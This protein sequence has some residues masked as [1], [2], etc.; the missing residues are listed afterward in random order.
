MANSFVKRIHYSL[1]RECYRWLNKFNDY[2]V[3][4]LNQK[5]R[6]RYVAEYRGKRLKKVYIDHLG[7][8]WFYTSAITP[9]V[10][11]ELVDRPEEAD[12]VIFL[13]IVRE[14]LNII[15]K[16]VLIVIREPKDYAQ[17]YVN[18]LSKDF[19]KNNRVTVLSHLDSPEYFIHGRQNL[20]FIR[21]FFYPNFH[22]WATTEV[23]DSLKN[24]KRKKLIFALTSGLSGIP[25]NDLR[26]QFISRLSEANNQFDF[27]GR[28]SRDAFSLKN[29]R[30]LCSLKYRLLATYK[31][32]LILENSPWEEG[33]ITE[34]IFDALICGC[35]PIFHGT[36]K[37]FDLL[38]AKWFYYLP[39]LDDDE[40]EKLNLFLE[41]DAYLEIAN[42]RVQIAHFID[43]KFGFYS[44]I[45][46]YINGQDVK[47]LEF[48]V[49]R[50]KSF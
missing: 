42:N 17:L 37:I 3:E 46:K 29:Y 28:F 44:M 50:G 22:H 5:L 30:G 19:F 2:R 41:T 10:S 45:E 26:K 48:E 1:A 21:S 16:D 15:N 32:N 31:Y 18:H 23:L 47:L 4:R 38:P 33:Y 36:N 14:E 34:K 43:Q 24:K 25:G 40:V 7:Y 35:M 49:D 8:E 12:L 13:V 9:K 39:S 6:D 27:Y 11:Y 20:H